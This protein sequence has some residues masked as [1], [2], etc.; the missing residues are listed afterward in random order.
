MLG[1]LCNRIATVIAI[2]TLLIFNVS[3]VVRAVAAEPTS[4]AISVSGSGE[5]TS[6]APVA[7]ANVLLRGPQN[8]TALTDSHGAFAFNNVTQGIY[9]LS[10]TKPGYNTALQND[11]ALLPG[12][13]QTLAVRIDRLTFSSLRTIA[14]V[15]AA[16]RNSIN[17]SPASV[18]IATTQSFINQAQPQVTRVLN[19]IPGIQIS[20]P[21]NSSNGASPG[22][23]TIP[24]IRA[25]TSYE[26]AS[27]IDG[28]P[29]SVGQYGDNVTTFL[30]SFMFGG[31][32]VIKGPGAE[33]PVVNNAIGGTTNFRTLDPTAT[34][35]AQMLLGVDNRGGTLS[36]FNYSNTVGRIGFV[37]DLAT[38]NNPSALFGKQIY[39]DPTGGLVN[40]NTLNGAS[41]STQVGNT[42]TFIPTQFPLVACCYTLSG[43]YDQVAELLKARYKVSPATSLTVSYLAGQTDSDQTGN[44][45]SV[46]YG[47][48]TPGPGYSGSL[49]P[50][51]IVIASGAS[52][53]FPGAY[54][55]EHNI[56]PIFQAEVATTL[57][58]DSILARYY[59]ASILRYQ[60]QG[61]TNRP[62]F[63]TANLFGTSSGS[64]NINA[65]FNGELN[66]VGY[67]DYYQEPELDKLSGG[68]LQYQHPIRNGDLTFS[69]DRTWS[70][71]SD[72]SVFP[73]P[74]YSFNLPP[75]TNQ[76]LTTYLLRGHFF[77]GPRLDLTL[78][79]YLN[80]YRFVY[81][82]GCATDCNTF[83]PAVLGTGVTFDTSTLSH[84][85]PRVALAYRA[86]RDSVV[87][88]AAGSSIAPPFL[89]LLSSIPSAAT[90]TGGAYAT[91][92][93]PNPNLRP[94]TAFGWDLGADVRLKDR[95]TVASGDIYSTNLFNRF[96]SQSI[97]SG[98]VC[99]TATPCASSGPVPPN[100]P[101]LNQT[102][103]NISNA[104]FQGV[105]LTVRRSPSYGFGY[106]ASGALQKGYYY[107]LPPYFY[108]SIPGPGCT[109]DQ[110]LNIISG[111]NTNG[112][113]IYIPG[114]GFS[115]N[116]N[117]RIP[118]SQA[119]AELFYTGR[120]GMYASFGETYYG[121]NNA[122][123]EP[124]FRIAYA[125]VR[126]PLEQHLALQL[127][128][129]NIFNA[130][131][132]IMP[133]Y[134]GGLPIPLA[135]GSSAATI[136][137]VLGPAT[138]RLMLTTRLP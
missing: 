93:Q 91:E 26:T 132:G 22:S 21:S 96:F 121:N 9:S 68:S 88:F 120:N 54:N 102:N 136:G 60:Y 82:A 14:D 75:G 27:L 38:N 63:T 12:Q 39:Y 129:D 108:C 79:N 74:F 110:N 40:G 137:N 105:E 114:K 89:G 4:T 126:V 6:G 35:V 8:Y 112:V 78:S 83:G 42:A 106:E 119:N 107:N 31:V 23:I 1:R 25:A 95:V 87:R 69:V 115:Y 72:Y 77:V 33:S 127:S 7:G 46:I 53:F 30:N 18:S 50:G 125:T 118:Y 29:I 64:G 109:M 116:G 81:P 130:Y 41:T 47:Q 76:T 24:N 61:A 57:N 117:M 59:H 52:N 122:L 58:R 5:E 17:T 36:N 16:G 101:I 84:N 55:A 67:N 71:S 80:T 123:N 44:T 56:E 100:T 138:Y 19:Q 124:A 111:Q 34:A 45:A 62:D 131:P 28:H 15:R 99:S 113:G 3:T 134:G 92:T 85:D 66:S 86:S 73:G 98:Q 43:A 2:A 94:E 13:A 48:F 11:I 37:V 90:Y 97:D 104:R 10:V 135:D 49:K 128:G 51:P 20:L 32:E 133:I 65:T 70:D 103:T